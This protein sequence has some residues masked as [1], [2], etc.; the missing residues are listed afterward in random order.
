MTFC[1]KPVHDPGASSGIGLV[2]ARQAAGRGARVVVAARN[3]AAV[4]KL[5]EEIE[6]SGRG[7]AAAVAADVSDEY[8]LR[9][10]AE[11]TVRRFGRIDTWVEC[12]R[13]VAVRQGGRC[14]A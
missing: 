13:C 8:A 14:I 7:E 1:M 6:A 12:C 11:A 4:A 2:T 9:R 5:A 3:E 10:V